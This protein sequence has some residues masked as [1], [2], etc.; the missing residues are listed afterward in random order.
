MTPRLHIT[1]AE[2]LFRRL[3]YTSFAHL[4][5]TTGRVLDWFII[6]D[7]SKLY[8]QTS[9]DERIIG[10]PEVILQF[11]PMICFIPFMGFWCL[12][13]SLDC[14]VLVTWQV[15]GWEGYGWVGP[16]LPGRFQ[17][18]LQLRWRWPRNAAC[19]L[20]VAQTV[21]SRQTFLIRVW[22]CLVPTRDLRGWG[23][24]LTRSST[25]CLD[26]RQRYFVKRSVLI[27]TNH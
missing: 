8:F 25:R 23:G 24:T 1:M 26:E 27:L 11:P 14:Q 13:Y 22:S 17:F 2:S 21:L 16:S 6:I 15:S 20:K 19:R 18:E 12:F 9:P 4:P 3:R 10:S 5:C 7:L